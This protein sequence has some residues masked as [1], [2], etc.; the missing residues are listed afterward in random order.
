M[1]YFIYINSLE[2][3]VTTWGH[4]IRDAYIMIMFGGA[5]GNGFVPSFDQAGYYKAV[6]QNASYYY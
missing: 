3:I 6:T 2:D 4:G 1:Y 5:I